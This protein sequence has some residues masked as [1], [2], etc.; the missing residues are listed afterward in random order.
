MLNQIVAIILAFIIDLIIGDPRHWPHPVKW[1]GTFINRLE[2]ILYKGPNKKWHGFYMLCIVI[3]LTLSVSILIVS[4]AYYINVV[5]GIVTEAVL[6]ATT[7]AQKSLRQDSLL[8]YHP[9]QENNISLARQ[10]LSELVSRDTATMDE[11]TIVRSTVETVAENINDF[12]T[13]PLFWALIGGAPLAL[14]Y[15][16][17]NT[18]DSMVGYKNKRYHAYGYAAAT[19]DDIVNFLP[20]RITSFVMLLVNQRSGRPFKQLWQFVKKD[21]S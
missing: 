2:I 20:A 1:L 4:L 9:L 18:A 7:I 6:I 19:C 12:V 16:A 13:A 21:A 3:I 8:V 11:Q 5:L 10:Q 14:V 17:I 15:R